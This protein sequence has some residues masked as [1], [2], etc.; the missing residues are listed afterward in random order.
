[1]GLV[2]SLV[3]RLASDYTCSSCNVS[4]KTPIGVISYASGSTRLAIN[5]VETSLE[6]SSSY[7]D[8]SGI[9]DYTS[10]SA[11]LNDF[12]G[13]SNTAAWVSYHGSSTSR[14]APGYC[15]NYTTTGTSKG[16]WYLPAA[17]E[18]YASIVTNYSA[19]NSG[20]SAAGGTQLSG[21]YWSSSEYSYLFA[22]R[23]YA[24]GG[25]NYGGKGNSF[26]VRCVLAF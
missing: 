4:G 21:Y 24:N 11:A 3:M 15:Y 5:L 7:V 10:N 18:L 2:K 14:Y 6:W 13:K 12:S 8:I 9:T 23:V 25:V 22:W 19:V 16:Q 20:L 17:G 26:Y 1:M